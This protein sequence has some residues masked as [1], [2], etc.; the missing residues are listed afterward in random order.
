MNLAA[1]TMAYRDEGTI[2]GTLACLAPVVKKHIVFINDKPFHGDYEPPDA[3]EDI[4][5]EFPNVEVVKGNWPEHILRNIGLSL[6][7]ECDWV[8]GFNADEMMTQEDLSKLKLYLSQTA[9]DAVG[10]ISK[11][12]W[13]TTD[14]RFDP[15][16]DFVNVCVVRPK[17]NARYFDTQ[18]IDCPYDSLHYRQ[19]PF[20]T[21]HHL[22]YCA[23]K[24]ILSKITHYNHAD[25]FDGLAWYEKH[26]KN[27][28]P[29]QP[30]YQPFG[31]KWE[32]VYDPLPQELV[33]LLGVAYV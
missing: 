25:E 19:P 7:K 29:G 22:S 33:N 32:A 27:W 31:T 6:C 21:H 30:V 20:I 4:C 9:R 14:Y 13:K 12:Y 15:D 24:D 1:V 17:S 10:F 11:V 18:C 5:R 2:R 8:L 26:F 16:P 28:K 23:P 3:T